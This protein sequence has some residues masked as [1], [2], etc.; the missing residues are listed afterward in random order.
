[1]IPGVGPA[2]IPTEVNNRVLAAEKGGKLWDNVIYGKQE[3]G[4]K[5]NPQVIRQ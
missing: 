5:Y 1:M 4:T 3:A 2:A